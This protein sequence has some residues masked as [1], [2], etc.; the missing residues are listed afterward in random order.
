MHKKGKSITPIFVFLFCLLLIVAIASLLIG[1]ASFSFSIVWQLRFPRLLLAIL[2]GST[3]AISGGA[4]QG[5]LRNPL[6]DPYILGISSG[7]AC[8]AS[9]ALISGLKVGLLGSLFVPLMAFTGG[10][11]T[12]FVVYHLAKVGTKIPSDTLLLSGV[13][14]GSFFAALIM[15][16]MALARRELVEIIYLLMGNLGIIFYER[17]IPLFVVVAAI[18]FFTNI[19]IF[20]HSRDLNL[21]SLGEEEAQELGVEIEMV[22]RRIFFVTSLSIGAMVSLSGAIGFIGL[23]IPHLARILVGPDYRYLIPT[24]FLMGSSLLIIADTMARTICPFEIPVGVITALFGVPFFIYLLR[25]R[26]K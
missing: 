5:I 17:T 24:S 1:P 12:I 14:I 9:F 2:V 6:A 25:L 21:F 4:L 22:K 18:A 20:S 3:L 23:V 7:A 10:V 8:G 15:L 19:I 13:I 16:I 11:F 26:K